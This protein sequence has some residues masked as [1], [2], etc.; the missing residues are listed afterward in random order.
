MMNVTALTSAGG[1]AGY[2]TQDNYYLEKGEASAQFY[3]KGAKE[4]GLTEQAVTNENVTALLKGQL[5]SGT[6]VGKPDNHRPG[7]DATF[8]APKSVSIQALVAGDERIQTAHDQ[9]V[10]IALDHYENHLTTRQRVDG[11]IEKQITGSLV[12][13]TFQH[14][15]SRNLDPQLHTHAVVMNITQGQN[16]D[17]RSVSSESLYR[18]Q[19]ELDQVYKTELEARLNALGYRTEKTEQGFELKSV[20]ESARQAFS[21]RS[22]Q[23]EAELAKHNLTRQDSTAEQRQTATLKTRQAKPTEQN[24]EILQR[25]WRQ[26]A[27]DIG[28]QPELKPEQEISQN[29]KLLSA[30]VEHTI[31]VLTEKDAVISEHAIYRHLNGSDQTAVSK[32]QLA[33]NLNQLKS[34]DKLHSRE[35]SAFDRHTRLNL[36]EPAIV[37]E[38][39]RQLETQMLSTA[40]RMNQPQSPS[41][42]GK[43]SPSL[44]KLALNSGYFKGG[45]ITSPKAAAK[46]IDTKIALAALKGHHWTAE[47]RQAAIGILSHR[48]NLTQLQGYAGTAKTSSVLASIRDIAQREGYTV[49]AIAPSHAASQ[50]LQKDI[51]ADRALT[52]SGY[53]AQMQSGQLS[54]ELGN[55]KVLVIH[56]EAGLASTAQ[57]RDLLVQTEKNGHR[58]LN[59]GDRYQKASIGAGSAFGQ[60]MDHKVPTYELT[61]IFRQKDADLKQVV[62]HSLPSA[63][64]VQEAMRLLNEK[65]RIQQIKSSEERINLLAGQYT[66]LTP[67]QRQKTLLIDPTRKGVD[68]LNAT[69]REQ[70]QEKSEL[71]PNQMTVKTLH[72]QDIAKVDL[73]KGAVGSVF[74]VGQVITLNSQSLKHQDKDLVKGTKWQ[75]IQLNRD[76]NSLNVQ[77]MQQPDLVKTLSGKELIK[78]H[79]SVSE[80]RDT[81]LSVGDEVRFT[82]SDSSKGI[83]T[84]EA[85]T[86][87][88]IDPQ[89][90]EVHLSKANGQ[91]VTLDS[92]QALNLDYNYAKTT[93]SSQ[94][95][96]AERVLYHAQSTST[97][98][99]NQRD[100]YVGLSRATTEITVVTDSKRDLSDL[101]EK[102]TGEKHSALEKDTNSNSQTL[103]RENDSQSKSNTDKSIEFSTSKD[104]DDKFHSQSESVSKETEDRTSVD[105]ATRE[106]AKSADMDRD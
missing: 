55:S 4:L 35:I 86:V 101:I 92:K 8:S 97:N 42:L 58:L 94:G 85:A 6:Q 27:K 87:K 78:T 45:A 50:Q 44:E 83:L 28:W 26:Q 103:S 93:F 68:A 73:E 57:M 43:I 9:A 20:P 80:L 60:L 17:W 38:Q 75:I 81:P 79:A 22:S 25:G 63:P 89:T 102:S 39:G 76:S 46:Q 70:L 51:Q 95:Q 52:T 72:S 5:P 21:T 65:G 13:A 19:R 61:T 91:T 74:T 88:G 48:G 96:T 64:K 37:T 16:G 49:V 47:Q 15:T 36:I 1:A 106:E 40:D 24:R 32:Q 10:K 54:K 99:M 104:S 105:S 67:E 90:G 11:K 59:S 66:Q 18:M 34:E 31:A 12:A 41:W 53:L 84:N 2:L 56:D 23:V 82:A 62:E 100:F 71:P 30:R 14:Q 98:L 7:W 69:I 29:Q 33:D 3:G 77:S